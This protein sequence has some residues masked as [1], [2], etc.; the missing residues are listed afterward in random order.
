MNL[1]LTESLVGGE[2]AF[3]DYDGATL[4]YEHAA[5]TGVA[6]LHMHGAECL[7]HAGRPVKAGEKWLLRTDA[8]YE[9]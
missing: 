5:E 3:W 8:V 4:L 1:G 7:P 9:M 2:T 6:L